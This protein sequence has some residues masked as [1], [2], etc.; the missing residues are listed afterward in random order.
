MPEMTP[1]TGLKK[2][3]ESENADITVINENM[4][5]ID[6]ALGDLAGVPTTAKDAAG[7]IA[8][9]FTNVSDGKAV[10]A[11]AITDKGVPTDAEDTFAEMAGNIEAIPVGPDTSDATASAADIVASKT[12]YGADGTKLTGTM[13]DRGNMSFT[14]GPTAQ[15]IPAGKHGG[16]GQVA[17]VVV[18]PDKVLTGTTIAGTLGTMH[19]R[20]GDNLAIGMEPVEGIRLY[21]KPPTGYYDG[22]SDWVYRAESNFTTENIKSGVN[23]FGLLGTLDPKVIVTGSVTSNNAPDVYVGYSGGTEYSRSI[24]ITGHNFMPKFIF[25]CAP[26]NGTTNGWTVWQDTTEFGYLNSSALIVAIA[27]VSQIAAPRHF[28]AGGN[29]VVSSSTVVLPVSVSNFVHNYM[30]LG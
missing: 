28:R 16:G 14:P 25:V 10:I 13:V 7:A 11:S 1:H 15:T 17:A 30:I 9:L 19:H 29:M 27:V 12:A 26:G 5:K 24:T 3:Q 22:N 18:P 4:D 20:A 6:S 21:L 8:E 2:P 23:M